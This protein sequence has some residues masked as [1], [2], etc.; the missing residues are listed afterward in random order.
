MV[1]DLETIW[2]K[3]STN[4]ELDISQ[5]NFNT[6]F[7]DTFISKIEDGVVTIAVPNQF[8]KNWLADKFHK[9]ILKHLINIDGTI[10]SIDYTIE[11]KRIVKNNHA[12]KPPQPITA[13]QLILCTSTKMITSI[14]V[15]LL[16]PLL[17]VISMK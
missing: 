1:H 10:R 14:L 4:I 6:W 13:Y 11:K 8:V 7:K 17:W 2:E 5:A 12:A 16:R 3:A 15:I 9:T